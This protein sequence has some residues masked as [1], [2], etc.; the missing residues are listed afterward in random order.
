[1][2]NKLITLSLF[3]NAYFSI[4]SGFSLTPL[5]RFSHLVQDFI[6][7]NLYL[8]KEEVQ[9]WYLKHIEKADDLELISWECFENFNELED[10]EL[11]QN[12]LE[13]L[14]NAPF[15]KA[16]DKELY[17]DTFKPA[18][19]EKQCAF[20]FKV[21]RKSTQKHLNLYYIFTE[22]LATLHLLSESGK[23]RMPLIVENVQ[24]GEAIDDAKDGLLARFFASQGVKKPLLWIRG[25]QPYYS[26]TGFR[27]KALLTDG[28]M[29]VVG[30]DFTGVWHAGKFNSYVYRK[31]KFSY[32]RYVKGFVTKDKNDEMLQ[33][34]ATMKQDERHQ[35]YVGD[36]AHL[37]D[38]L[39]PTDRVVMNY[40]VAQLIGWENEQVIAWEQLA[41]AQYCFYHWNSATQMVEKMAEKL[42]DFGFS[43]EG[44]LYVIPE[45][46][47]DQG[48]LFL[49]SLERLPFK[50]VACFYRPFEAYYSIQEKLKISA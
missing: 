2:K 44:T 5:L 6:F 27:S 29:P 10:V 33:A 39:T 4:G 35:I 36:I 22:G 45:T 15:F 20:L 16:K 21:F 17:L 42:K 8:G 41:H 49:Q 19:S 38:R 28:P 26:K 48:G 14:R 13:H 23:K 50:T 25:H 18:M 3:E 31:G 43:G 7:C 40:H 37:K 46:T 30:M 12:Y 32:K 47:E 24:C 9:A 34:L 1:M 11:P